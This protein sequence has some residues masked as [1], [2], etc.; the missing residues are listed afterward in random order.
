[1]TGIETAAAAAITTATEYGLSIT[2]LTLACIGLGYLHHVCRKENSESRKENKEIS[3]K[4]IQALEK[5][6]ESNIKMSVSVENMAGAVR[7]L[8]QSVRMAK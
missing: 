7:E 8:S 5:Q 4:F 6:N 2:I 3:D 1:M